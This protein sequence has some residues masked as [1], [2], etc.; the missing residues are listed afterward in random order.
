MKRGDVRE[1]IEHLDKADEVLRL[2][3]KHRQP[4]G[5][6]RACEEA[7]ELL[8]KAVTRLLPYD[9]SGT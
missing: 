2:R 9:Q 8:Q 7:R 5:E 1:A 4:V 3:V 6:Q